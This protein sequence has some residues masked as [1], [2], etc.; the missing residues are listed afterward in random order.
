MGNITCA[1][2]GHENN[3]G[4]KFCCEC[5]GKLETEAVCAAC[6]HAN[7]AGIKFCSQCGKPLSGAAAGAAVTIKLDAEAYRKGAPMNVTVTGVSE[8]MVSTNAFVAIYR[9]DAP[10]DGWMDYRSLSAGNCQ[11][12]FEAPRDFGNYEMRAFR[13]D[14][15]YDNTT[16]VTSVPFTVGAAA[17]ELLCPAC[18]YINPE[19]T[20]FCN[21]CGAKLEAASAEGAGRFC[22]EC[23]EKNPA[24]RNFCGTCGAKL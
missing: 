16:F 22:P 2:C 5:G 24:D 18:E 21:E 17:G 9:A 4:L 7:K 13:K 12:E 8:H 14:G 6:G 19:G 15:P 23:G 3:E 11:L 10:Y 20:K 1:A